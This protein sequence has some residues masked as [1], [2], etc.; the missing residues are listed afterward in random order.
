ML[1]LYIGEEGSG[2]SSRIHEEFRQES[3]VRRT[4]LIVPE[5]ITF[6]EQK[7][8]ILPQAG[9]GILESEVLSFRRLAHRVLEEM[10]QSDL[11]SLDEVGKS[12][13]LYRIVQEELPNLSYYRASA[14]SQGFLKRLKDLFSEFAQYEA[15]EEELGKALEKAPANS[16]LHAKLSDYLRILRRYQEEMLQYGEISEKLLDRLAD[17]IPESEYLAGASVF[18]D[19]FYGYTPQQMR[20]F[21]A[22]LS[23]VRDLTVV[24]TLPEEA[25]R[26]TLASGRSDYGD[27]FDTGRTTLLR[28]RK[29]AEEQHEPMRIKYFRGS[30]KTPLSCM[31]QEFFR[32]GK[33]AERDTAAVKEIGSRVHLFSGQDIRSEVRTIFDRIVYLVRDRGYRY[34]DI[35][36]ALCDY[37]GYAPYLR[38]FSDEYGIPVFMDETSDVMAHPFVRMILSLFQIL[39]TRCSYDT[40]LS[41][42]KTGFTP[43]TREQTDLFD[44]M[45]LSRGW[46]GV[47][48][49]LEG[50]RTAAA[51]AENE[52]EA[53][54]YLD[55]FG[56][57]LDTA[58]HRAKA[59][60][61]EWCALLS[62]FL[63]VSGVEKVLEHQAYRLHE[64]GFYL[65]EAQCRQLYDKADAVIRRIAEIMPDTEMDADGFCGILAAGLSEVKVG[66][67]PP[68][69]D[70]I[71]AG[72]LTRSRFQ[73]LKALFIAG[74]GEDKFPH[75]VQDQGLLLER[76][77]EQL[78]D[79][80][81]LAPGGI[82][83][84]CDQQF[85]LYIL[86]NA[87]R[88]EL[89][90]SYEARM[91]KGEARD[92]SVFW[93][94]F[95]QI[96]GP[97][98]LSPL[99]SVLSL[100]EPAFQRF[101]EAEVKDHVLQRWFMT[102]EPYAGR[103]AGMRGAGA[104][105]D[106]SISEASAEELWDP[107][108]R[109][110]SITRM[111]TYGCCPYRYFLRYGLRLAERSPFE[112]TLA[113]D[114]QVLHSVMEGA[115]SLLQRFF[116]EDV[117][118]AEI[119]EIVE[120]LF[121][122]SEEQYRLYADNSRYHYFWNKLKKNA[123]H[124]LIRMRD[125]LKIGDFRP[126]Y[127]EWK[128]GSRKGSS[129]P[130][131]V[132]PLSDGKLLRIDGIVDR[133]D[134]YDQDGRTYVRVIDY[135]SGSQSFSEKDIWD[136]VS[137]QLP[138][139]LDAVCQGL[140]RQ[141]RNVRPAGILYFS[142]T[143]SVIAVED[144]WDLEKIEDKLRK[145]A[146]LEGVISD[147]EESLAGM[148]GQGKLDDLVKVRTVKSGGINKADIFKVRSEQELM[149]L[150]RFTEHRIAEFADLSRKGHIAKLPFRRGDERACSRCPYRDCCDYDYR[151]RG[152]GE[153]ESDYPGSPA[154]WQ[155]MK[156]EG[157][158]E[159]RG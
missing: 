149:G 143:P 68:E 64:D 120:K 4:V 107:Q 142:L 51:G 17:A 77:R 119:Q 147:S 1:K 123:G 106:E 96:G 146:R 44:N 22:L 67:L 131:L 11:V 40:F 114:G 38:Q 32:T 55:I 34:R 10:G 144:D 150:S 91:E 63:E 58:G 104:I 52:E 140:E 97:D 82:G 101:C 126:E 5:Q 87:P 24:L 130:P 116:S 124:S 102:H 136:G 105:V 135:K 76:E 47:R 73:D 134:L 81:T 66:M 23:R 48:R 122:A 99:P 117:D 79:V 75:I 71:T 100:A 133:V 8:L 94:R 128:F 110:V 42:L 85:R 151:I 56:R 12:M 154:F 152:A 98:V 141:G 74:F 2:R 156:Q 103:L 83:Q 14:H 9:R 53:A 26:Q 78:A 41:F 30:R 137:M 90:V 115:G 113:D 112:A 139:Y 49:M 89:Y 61:K 62:R 121:A 80:M 111:E 148:A 72:D 27:L 109:E 6:N 159:T 16:S 118:D 93:D 69:I 92:P 36:I 31:A 35:G 70:Q 138:V 84:I 108:G 60:A 21:G 7:K 65:R 28:F 157:A 3:S 145:D 127:F 45:A 57:F 20:V 88:E 153:R 29:L 50:L 46:R 59:P 37:P 129:L 15:G 95:V 19:D 155:R 158:D 33:P 54:L 43:F 13:L 125:Q 25:A 86:L 132:V 39:R 18:A